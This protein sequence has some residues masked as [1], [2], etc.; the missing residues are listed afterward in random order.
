MIEKIQQKNKVGKV[1]GRKGVAMQD[2]HDFYCGTMFDAYEFFGAHPCF[3]EGK[4]GVMFRVYAPNAAAVFVAGD[5]NGWQG[6]EMTKEGTGGVFTK[7]LST[8]EPNMFYKYR[9]KTKDGRI[10]EKSDPYGFA[11]ELRPKSASII[12][13]LSSYSFSDSSYMKKREKNYDKPMNIYEIHFGSW[14]QKEGRENGWYLYHELAEELIPYL[15]EN[16]YTHVELLPLSEHPADCSWGYQVTGFFAPTSRYGTPRDLM[17]FVNQCHLAGIGVIMD[18]VPV[19][20]AVDDYGLGMFDGTSL[21][22]YPSEDTGYSEWGSY[23]FN[24]YR[25]EVCSF[26]QS[27]ANYWLSVYHIDGL[28]MDAV[29]NIIYWKGNSNKGVNQGGLT[30]LKRMN[31]GLH[32]NHPEVMLIAEDSSSYTK[33]TAPVEY[34]GLGFDYKWDMGFMN[35]TLEYFKLSPSDRPANY[36]KLTFSMHYFYYELF[37]LAFS[38]DEVVHGKATILQKMW[39]DYEYKFPQARTLYTYMYTHPG[40]KLNF[41]GNEIGHFREWNESQEVD[42]ML[43]DFPL[44]EGFHKYIKELSK[45]YSKYPALYEG[46]YNRESFRWLEVEAEKECVYIY[47]R[48]SKTE[49]IIVVMN[50]SDQL[51]EEF[52]FGYDKPKSI[53]RLLSSDSDIFGGTDKSKSEQIKAKHIEYKSFE[54]SFTT[55]LAP[56]SSKVFL[57]Q[58]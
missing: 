15:K 19:H 18:F 28:R 24:Y 8:A 32:K 35:D 49:S 1:L 25:G 3:E 27:A 10:L 17:D 56:F 45:L 9:I 6:D 31:S 53:K 7:F 5:F 34:D 44:H 37:L 11:M 58:E 41:M 54:Y 47:E 43:L 12:V 16:N 39:G 48:Q 2:L 14:K 42:W 46:E 52:V 38:H 30:F 26:L 4:A 40:K 33:V 23:S 57:V 13:D 51:Q 50:L 29:S 22:E 20:F 55:D 21:Y 36:H